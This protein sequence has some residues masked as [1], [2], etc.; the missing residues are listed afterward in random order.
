MLCT[1]GVKDA[2]RIKPQKLILDITLFIDILHNAMDDAI[3]NTV[4]YET[5]AKQIISITKITK[6]TLIESLAE[7]LATFC[8]TYKQVASVTIRIDKPS[9][10]THLAGSVGVEITRFKLTKKASD[11]YES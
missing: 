11:H 10:L 7:H 4:N 3:E 5:V 8:L 9:A 6:F 2:E 1:I